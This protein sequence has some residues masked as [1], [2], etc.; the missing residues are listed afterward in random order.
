MHRSTRALGSAAWLHYL[1]GCNLR[2]V[3]TLLFKLFRTVSSLCEMVASTHLHTELSE[4]VSGLL[5][6]EGLAQRHPAHCELLL[7]MTVKPISQ[8]RQLTLRD[9]K[10]LVQ[11][12]EGPMFPE[13]HL[14]ARPFL[15][16]PTPLGV[17]RYCPHST[18]AVQGLRS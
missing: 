14:C 17:Q 8:V 9:L 6:A 5:L 12:R 1:P 10:S 16:R 3:Q 2:Q 15:S 7:S 11:G 13:R 18:D 4:G